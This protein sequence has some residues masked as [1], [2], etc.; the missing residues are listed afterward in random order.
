RPNKGPIH[1][2]LPSWRFVLGSGL[3]LG[4][5]AIAAFVA[6][7]VMID[8][9]EPED[10]ALAQGSTV[11]YADGETEMGSF[12]SI[13][14]TIIDAEELPDH[15]GQAVVASEDRRFYSN[16]GVDPVG[17]ARAFVNNVLGRPQ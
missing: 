7:Y 9:P 14:R 2:W 4:V 11:Y 17:I 5:L 16:V 12:A 13:N 6:A 3:T 1:R 8:V 10:V 15:V